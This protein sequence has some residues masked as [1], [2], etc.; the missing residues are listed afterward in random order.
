M[1]SRLVFCSECKNL[2]SPWNRF[3]S[4]AVNFLTEKKKLKPFSRLIGNAQFVETPIVTTISVTIS[5]TVL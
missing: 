1:K 4:P 3:V 5:T 2:N